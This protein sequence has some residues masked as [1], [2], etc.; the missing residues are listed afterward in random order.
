MSDEI[1]GYDCYV[2]FF[3]NEF[4]KRGA[5]TKSRTP[6]VRVGRVEWEEISAGQK[7]APASQGPSS[8]QPSFPTWRAAVLF[9]SPAPQFRFS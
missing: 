1:G 7:D 6:A 5:L 2:A 9:T 4:S 8:D 3:G